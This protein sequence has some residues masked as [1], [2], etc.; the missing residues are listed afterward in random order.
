MARYPELPRLH[1]LE[2]EELRNLYTELQRWGATLLNE[3]DTRD[4]QV[5][6]RP[7]TNILPKPLI[8]LQGKAIIEHII[9]EFK[10]YNIK[11]YFV[12]INYKSILSGRTLAYLHRHEIYVLLLILPIYLQYYSSLYKFAHLD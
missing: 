1:N 7:S 9:D 6:S 4:V 10:L 8:P 12:S 3:L 5:D 11:K 2:T